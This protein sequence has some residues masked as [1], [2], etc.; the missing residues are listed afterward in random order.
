M[1]LLDKLRRISAPAGLGVVPPSGGELPGGRFEGAWGATWLRRE[2]FAC[3]HIHGEVALGDLR[4]AAPPLLAEVARDPALSGI[5]LTRAVFFDSETTSLGGGVST[6]VFLL[7]LGWFEGAEFVVEQHFLSDL[8]EEEALLREVNA[9]FARFDVAVSFHGKGFDAPRLSGRL[10]FHRLPLALPRN[11]LDLCQIARSLYR[12]AFSDCRLQTLER[13]LVAFRRDDDLPGAECPQAYFSYLQGDR[14]VIPRVFEHNLLDVLTLPAMAVCF[15]RE[16]EAPA[17][18]VVLANLGAFYEASGRDR[19]ARDSYR[20]ALAGLA[21]ARHAL[22]PRSLERLAL[23]ERRAGRH[24]ESAA[25]LEVR[26]DTQPFSVQ[27]LE[28][29]S[30][31]FEHRVRDFGR[32]EEA[33]LDARSRL[34]TG[35]ISIEP[36]LRQQALRSLDHR[37]DRL[38]R[39]RGAAGQS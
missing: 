2:R 31:H 7:G 12:G 26:R 19:E 29:L 16:I 8:T 39:R 20:A 36:R 33:A 6:Y 18:P 34:L 32:A 37:L 10:A 38:R 27:A 21:Q 15:S 9:R 17:H 25:L 24:A 28:D 23:L 14:S 3:R 11:H 30:K 22:Y 13:A 5:D 1:A 4:R 35:K